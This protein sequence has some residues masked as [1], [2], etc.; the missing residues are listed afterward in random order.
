MSD[1]RGSTPSI[2]LVLYTMV[3]VNMFRKGNASGPWLDN[4]RDHDV[5]SEM[6]VYSRKAMLPDTIRIVRDKRNPRTGSTHYSI[7]P[8]RYM[9]ML[10]FVDELRALALKATLVFAGVSGDAEVGNK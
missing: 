10:E 7:R 9:T 2:G 4:V 5:P 6:V 8:A 1:Y 3:P